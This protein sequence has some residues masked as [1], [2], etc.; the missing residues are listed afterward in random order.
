MISGLVD[1]DEFWS[2]I[3]VLRVQK[4]L[5]RGRLG[6][7]YFWYLCTLMEHKEQKEKLPADL[8]MQELRSATDPMHKGLEDNTISKKLMSPEVSLTDY[9]FYLRCMGEVIK[10]FDEL[11]LPCVSSVVTDFEQRKKHQDIQQDLDFLYANGAEDRET[12]PFK[13][14]IGNPSLAYAL[15]YAYVIEGSTLGGRVILKQVAPALKLDG[16]G[17]RFFTGYGAETGKF[18][19]EYLQH[20]GVHILRNKLEQEAI[21]GAID[22]FTDIGIHFKNQE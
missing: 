6:G 4:P 14:F 10:T 16:P 8:F 22:G 20:F 2:N 19:K 13:G 1:V 21:Q 5:K 11:V 15:G 12:K 17:T 9:A 3:P 18:W 7:V